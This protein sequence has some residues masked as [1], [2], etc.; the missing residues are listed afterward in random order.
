MS[1][2]SACEVILQLPGKAKATKTKKP[3]PMHLP[4]AR[5]HGGESSSSY[6]LLLQHGKRIFIRARIGWNSIDE[7]RPVMHFSRHIF[8]L[9][10]VDLYMP[11]LK[12]HVM[13]IACVF[14]CTSM[15]C[16]S[17]K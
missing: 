6:Y 17:R 5:Q 16:K 9:M 13:Y 10:T 12:F 3:K 1:E 4:F 2:P 14:T 8:H 15:T 7:G 11:D